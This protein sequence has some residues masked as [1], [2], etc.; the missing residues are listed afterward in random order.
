VTRQTPTILRW[1]LGQQMRQLREQAGITLRAAAKEIE[2]SNATM[3][4]IEGGKQ[5][6]R[7]LYV[8]L[9][10]AMYGVEPALRQ[11]LIDLAAE[12]GKSEWYAALA[13][14][15]PDWFKQYLGYESSANRRQVY[16]VELIDG[17]FQTAD[18]ARTIARVNRPN[19][20]VEEIEKSISVRQGRQERLT[21]DDPLRLHVVMNEASL[22]RVVGSADIMRAQIEQ[23]I[24]VSKLPN[25]TVQ[26]L[27]FAAGAH[28]AMTSPFTLLGFDDYPGM[29]TVYL[30][31]G[32]GALYVEG[33]ADVERYSWMFGQLSDL[34]LSPTKS[35]TLLATVMKHL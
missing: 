1:Q 9:L 23:V 30:E 16:G 12:A 31:N 28:P 25:V 4:K 34:A 8:K 22:H 2:S 32:R 21:G 13:K 10:T 3:S 19:A 27:S 11:E 15:Y 7:P 29:N 35:R 33:E 24:S 20:G 18:Y 14:H 6:A 26:V 17:L 5:A